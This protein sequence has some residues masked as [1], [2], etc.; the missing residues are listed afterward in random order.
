MPIP[1][2][3]KELVLLRRQEERRLRQAKFQEAIQA[4]I[5]GDVGTAKAMLRDN[6]NAGVGFPRL[7][8][9]TKIQPKSLMR[10]FEPNGDPTA[11]KLFRVIAA[12]QDRTGIYLEVR[13]VD[14]H[15][16]VGIVI[17]D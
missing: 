4:L 8:A 10:M 1:Q 3:V 9:A 7:A 13:A 5:D 11:A 15:P 14:K 2:H 12:L 16:I 17:N 6:I